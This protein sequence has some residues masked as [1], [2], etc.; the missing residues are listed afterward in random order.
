MKNAGNN[1]EIGKTRTPFL[2]RKD[3]PRTPKRSKIGHFP[4]RIVFTLS[5]GLVDDFGRRSYPKRPK[6]SF[7]TRGPNP[8]VLIM[9]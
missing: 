7:L 3:H 5:L 2:A 1:G 6:T 4:R 8:K 9:R